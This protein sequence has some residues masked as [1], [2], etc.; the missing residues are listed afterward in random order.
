M[1]QLSLG[2]SSSG[3][4]LKLDPAYLKEYSEQI[5]KMF[6][7]SEW[8]NAPKADKKNLVGNTIY[9]HV[10][11]LVGPLK[12]PKITGMLIDLPELELNYSISKWSEFEQKVMSAYTLICQSE[13]S[14]SISS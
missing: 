11:H 5:M 7:S 4:N 8:K 14:Q 6:T 13:Q 12:A 3:H 2:G 9:P 10:E 1:S